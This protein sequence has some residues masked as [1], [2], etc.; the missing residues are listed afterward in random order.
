MN[1]IPGDSCTII[2]SQISD[3]N[4]V[5]IKF[6]APNGETLHKSSWRFNSRL[7][8][9]D[10]FKDCIKST[11]AQFQHTIPDISSTDDEY[12]SWYGKFKYKLRAVSRRS[13]IGRCRNLQKQNQRIQ[14]DII[15][16]EVQ[17]PSLDTITQIKLKFRELN[18]ITE[19]ISLNAHIRMSL[20]RAE[21]SEKST[22][23]FFNPAKPITSKTPMTSLRS[24][25]GL[26]T[27]D[28][29][30]METIAKTF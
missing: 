11:I 18:R 12:F 21:H 16:L 30:E 19:K 6:L 17:E 8:Q 9:S 20:F 28:P 14:Q 24:P 13:A 26:V 1:L 7:L 10:N 29:E 25:T 3:H 2:P 5:K 15:D 23:R 4:I 27:N 22:K